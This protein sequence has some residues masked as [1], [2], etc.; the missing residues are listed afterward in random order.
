MTSHPHVLAKLVLGSIID[1]MNCAIP[2]VYIQSSQHH[3]FTRGTV[4]SYGTSAYQILTHKDHDA[5][6]TQP[7]LHALKTLKSTRMAVGAAVDSK[8][9]HIKLNVYNAP[10][11]LQ[12]SQ[13]AQADICHRQGPQDSTQASVP[14][15]SMCTSDNQ[16]FQHPCTAPGGTP[17]ASP[18]SLGILRS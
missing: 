13:C 6:S 4:P 8:G 12:T 5:S 18:G 7:L 10:M 2:S 16:Q 14:D 15:I 3:L 1:L 11:A 9:F 17:A